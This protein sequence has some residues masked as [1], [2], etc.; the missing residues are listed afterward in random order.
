MVLIHATA[1][2]VTV[3]SAT[4]DGDI[5]VDVRSHTRKAIQDVADA[6][7]ADGFAPE[8]SAEGVVRFVR[9][10]YAKI[11]L[12]APPA[13]IKRDAEADSLNRVLLGR[14]KRRVGIVTTVEV[15]RSVGR[16]ST[17]VRRQCLEGCRSGS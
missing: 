2:S 10:D 13:T 1:A 8:Q 5:V 9:D 14:R 3:P 11:D 17:S 4:D 7:V 15:A 6:L 12:L 16:R